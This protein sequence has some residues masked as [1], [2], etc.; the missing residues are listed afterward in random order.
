MNMIEE[1]K[2]ANPRF[3]RVLAIAHQL[4]I[5]LDALVRGVIP[6]GPDKPRG[7]KIRVVLA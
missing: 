6:P 3:S 5:S 1:S 4:G 2:I 7:R